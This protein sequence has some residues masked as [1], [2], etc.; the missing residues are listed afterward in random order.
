MSNERPTEPGLVVAAWPTPTPVNPPNS[1]D[2]KA[3]SIGS[4]SSDAPVSVVGVDGHDMRSTITELDRMAYRLDTAARL[5]RGS[6][7]AAEMEA[8]RETVQ[9]AA[10]L[11][12][13]LLRA[14]EG[15]LPGISMSFVTDPALDGIGLDPSPFPSTGSFHGQAIEDTLAKAGLEAGPGPYP[16]SGK[17]W[18]LKGSED[19]SPPLF[20]V[21]SEPTGEW[22]DREGEWT[23]DRSKAGQWRESRADAL[24]SANLDGTRNEISLIPFGAPPCFK[25]IQ[26]LSRIGPGHV[27]DHGIRWP[28]P[29]D[30]CD[31]Q[32]PKGL[33]S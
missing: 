4:P 15:S 20:H 33:N 19:R 32:L 28:H 30:D 11:V 7:A 31:R 22:L 1:E 16:P 3:R 21:K 17:D 10:I 18:R 13:Q 29:C 5:C 27:C 24:A 14:V 12:A 23:T 6:P 2:P 25:P 9:R 8:E 26:A